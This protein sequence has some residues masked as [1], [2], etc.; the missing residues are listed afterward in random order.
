MKPVILIP[1]I[2]GSVLLIAGGTVLAIGIASSKGNEK[3]TNTYELTEDFKNI[4][5]NLGVTDLEFVPTTDGSKKVVCQE[6]KKYHHKVSVA[7][8]ELTITSNDARRWYET[9]FSFNLTNL[10]VTVYLPAG[11]F[12]NLKIEDSTGNVNIPHDYSFNNVNLKVSTGDVKFAANVAEYAEFNSSTGD[13]NINE[14]STKNLKVKAS[15]GKIN[16]NKV[17]VAETITAS[18]STGN[19]HFTDTKANKLDVNTSTGSITFTDTVV[20]DHIN[21][22]A[23]TGNVR[24]EDSDADTLTIQTSTGDV[25]GTLLTS[26]IFSAKS[27]TGKIDVPTSTTGGLCEIKTDTGDIKIT[28]KQ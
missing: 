25:K 11:E 19:I 7:N 13:F 1:I 24:F 5:T 26:K 20:A 4:T 3:E 17:T 16:L 12:N 8:D 2:I 22:K 27:D 28:I 15:T 10:K 21:A 9:W 14:M 23:S 18:A 6:T